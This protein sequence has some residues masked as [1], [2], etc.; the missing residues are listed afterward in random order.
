MNKCRQHIV[1]LQNKTRGGLAEANVAVDIQQV[2]IYSPEA[3]RT[4]VQRYATITKLKQVD[5]AM[6]WYQSINMDAVGDLGDGF[7][8]EPNAYL[9]DQLMK[10][11]VFSEKV[12]S[13]AILKYL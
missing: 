9:D 6:H 1:G 12:R 13:P 5:I 8:L 3:L 11:N 4:M 2:A 7:Q 10:L